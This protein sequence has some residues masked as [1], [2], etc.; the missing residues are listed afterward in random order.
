MKYLFSSDEAKKREKI[1]LNIICTF[2][3]N[4]TRVVQRL[5]L[6]VRLGVSFEKF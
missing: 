1:G 4:K 5:S 2:K 3:T 6:T